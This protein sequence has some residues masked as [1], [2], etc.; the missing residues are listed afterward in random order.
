[1]PDESSLC[2]EE[3]LAATYHLYIIS[4]VLVPFISF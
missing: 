4:I 2:A 3:S 1:M